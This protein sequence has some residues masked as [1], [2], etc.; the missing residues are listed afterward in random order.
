LNKYALIF[1][2]YFILLCTGHSQT[3]FRNIKVDGTERKYLLHL[4]PKDTL[5]RKNP[6]LIVLHGH[7]GNGKQVMKETGFNDISDREKFIV[8]YPY[9]INK[10]WNDGR[11]TSGEAVKYDDVKFIASIIDTTVSEFQADTSRIFAT[12]MSNGG[13]LSIYLAYKLNERILA[14]APVCA[15]IPENIKDEY[16][17]NRPVSIMLVNGTADP[18]VRYYGGKVG[19]GILKNRGFALSTEE[20]IKIFAKL[21]KCNPVPVIED[22][23][24][25]NE[26]DEC[27]AEKHN[28]GNGLNNTKVVLVKVINGG[29]SYPGGTQYLPKALVGNL[30]KDFSASELIWEFFKTRKVR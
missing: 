30:C 25:I 11:E 28:Y 20:T 22:I 13:F 26:D 6:L 18:L 8:I 16:N 3:E 24:D 21:N 12:G 10:G 19:F 9:G 2:L 1:I 14:A 15:N 29:H 17:F 7:G 23:P 5:S 27:F 4:P